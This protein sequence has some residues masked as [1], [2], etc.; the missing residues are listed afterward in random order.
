MKKHIKKL[1]ALVG[2]ERKA[3]MELMI[4][5]I[6]K[7]SPKKRE[8]LG[9]A[10]N[11]V[12]GKNLGKELGFNII[13]YGR[14]E[15]IDTEISV[16][17]IV[18]ISVGNPLK[19]DLTGTVT[20]KGSRFIKVAIENVP[21]WALKKHV[22]IDLYANDVTFRRMEENLLNLS[23]KGKDALEYS[24]HKRDP[25]KDN[26]EI[27]NKK[28]DFVDNSLNNSQKEA[29]RKALASKNF[30]LIHG[31]FGTGKTR[32]LIELIN[33]EYFLNSKILATAESNNAIDNILERLA[34]SNSQINLTRLGHPQRVDK[35][36]VKFTLAYKVEN[37]QLS[38]KIDK[39]RDEVDKLSKKRDE[40]IK[41]SPRYRRGYSDNEIYKMGMS[42]RGG[43]GVSPKIMNSMA[44][45]LDVNKD[46]DELHSEINIVEDRIIKDIVLNSD[47]ILSTNSSAALEDI[48]NIKF[49]VA[50]IDE[51]SQATIPSVLIP[52]AKANKFVLAGDHK[53][54]PPTIISKK[55]QSL[56]DTLFEKLINK[57]PDKSSL[58]NVQYRMNNRLME[59]PNSEF[60][61]SKL[62]GGDDVE[63]IIISDILEE[64][65]LSEIEEVSIEDQLISSKEPLIFVDTSRINRNREKQLKDSKSIV[66]ILEAE[67]T[68]KIASF[69][70]KLGV[71]DNDIGII[72]PYADQVNLI[73]SKTTIE[74]K[75]VDGF[76]GR[77]K[78]IIIIS[79][80]R[81]NDRGNI[82]F[83]NDL[84][85]LNVAL[86]RAKRKLIIIGNKDTLNVNPTYSRLIDYV[87]QNNG[88]ISM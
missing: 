32:T 54:L 10:I 3:E 4:N 22:R 88:L 50:I 73:K 76:Q 8:Q 63:D 59:F 67:L 83:L 12:K 18:L 9:R 82:G 2:E 46:I 31:P 1:V 37:H 44:K 29:L 39:L 48:E 7:L 51:A 77:E 33:Q 66:N 6:K 75:T 5:E 20:E 86:T 30:F 27:L 57:Y 35:E 26:E 14:R 43:R 64:S 52:I 71:S 23:I 85:R 19:S 70:Q 87:Y 62:D 24:L 11:R 65:K 61:N 25:Q 21:R 36:N 47:V 72:S 81:S 79:T 58:L 28:L 49:D 15:L 41:P 38:E 55:A 34:E 17:D 60:Y 53:Q 13:Q 68:L 40:F 69:Y 16:G 78:E 56:E 80:V 45:W 42:N 84:R 74:T